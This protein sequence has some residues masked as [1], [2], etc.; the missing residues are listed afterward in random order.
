MMD[1]TRDTHQWGDV[2]PDDLFNLDF[3][4]EGYFERYRSNQL[5]DSEKEEFSARVYGLY[6]RNYY[7]SGGDPSKID[8]WVAGY[9]AD[10]LFKALQGAPWGDIMDLPWDK[11]TE[12]MTA[13]GMRAFNIWAGVRNAL[14]RNPQASVTKLIGA[15]SV[16]H[17]VS[18]ETARADYYAMKNSMDSGKGIPEKFLKDPHDF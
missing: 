9:I 2:E 8:P 11:T 7:K 5:S 4:F 12:M 14:N 3:N 1:V 15:Q 18:Y 16:L 10:K 13:K 6:C 17:F